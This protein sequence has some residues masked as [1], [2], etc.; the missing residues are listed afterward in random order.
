MQMVSTCVYTSFHHKK[1]D[2]IF[3]K[4]NLS[5]GSTFHKSGHK[6]LR[7]NRAMGT[8]LAVTITT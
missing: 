1:N 6:T 8:I 3:V 2:L 4:L 7:K 5:L